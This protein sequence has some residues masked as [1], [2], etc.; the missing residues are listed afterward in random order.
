M[1]TKVIIL[2]AVSALVT[3]SFTFINRNS[4]VQKKESS[5]VSARGNNEP[6]GGFLIEDKM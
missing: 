2:V 1:K 4:R 3:L 6:S 5:E